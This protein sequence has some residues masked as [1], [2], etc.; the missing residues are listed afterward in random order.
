MRKQNSL[1]SINPLAIQID[2]HEVI[3]M[4]KAFARTRIFE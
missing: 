2:P 3:P 4:M 1:S